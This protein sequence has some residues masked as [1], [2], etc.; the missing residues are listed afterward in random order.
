M[1]EICTKVKV[2]NQVGSWKKYN[3]KIG[4]I[5]LVQGTHSDE[6]LF[7]VLFDHRVDYLYMSELEEVSE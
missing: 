4:T 1:L 6:K 3:G 2:C 5:E 7:R